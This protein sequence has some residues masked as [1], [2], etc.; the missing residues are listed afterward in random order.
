[1][2]QLAPG[3]EISALAARA[4]RLCKLDLEP[5]QQGIGKNTGGLAAPIVPFCEEIDEVDELLTL[6][7]LKLIRDPAIWAP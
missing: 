7:D 3:V 4:A 6:T 5:P 1:V 2:G